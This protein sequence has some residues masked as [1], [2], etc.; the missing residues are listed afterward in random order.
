M[1]WF[2]LLFPLLI[3]WVVSALALFFAGRIVSGKK[4]S[5]SE[6]FVIALVGPI[7]VGI[8]RF[9]IA[10]IFGPIISL[11]IALLVWLWAVKSI[12][13]VGWGATFLISILAIFMFVASVVLVSFVIGLQKSYFSKILNSPILSGSLTMESDL[14]PARFRNPFI[15]KAKML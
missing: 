1:E 14:S 9:I 3:G 15:L 10:F 6:A 7:L 4:A 2:N 12:F 5:L 11:I 13:G 8:T